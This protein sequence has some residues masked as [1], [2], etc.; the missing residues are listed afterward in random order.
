MLSLS[1]SPGIA[2]GFRNPAWGTPITTVG[3]D[4]TKTLVRK[5][6]YQSERFR[7]YRIDE[8]MPAHQ[9]LVYL[10]NTTDIVRLDT[11]D[12]SQSIQFE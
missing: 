1:F 2:F 7:R 3:H 5:G 12:N 10:S 9:A 6:T 4:V 8:T 11:L